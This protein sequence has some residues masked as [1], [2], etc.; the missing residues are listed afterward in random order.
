MM[1]RICAI[2]RFRTGRKAA[3]AR[4]LRD[5]EAGILFNE[6]IVKMD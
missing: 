4:L 2:F 6:H 5:S 1:A 3:L